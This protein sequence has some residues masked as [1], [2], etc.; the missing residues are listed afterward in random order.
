MF[1]AV[2]LPL[3]ENRTCALVKDPFGVGTVMA[4]QRWNPDHCKGC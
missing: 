4:P 1:H 3:E 2:S